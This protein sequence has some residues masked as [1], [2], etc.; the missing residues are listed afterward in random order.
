MFMSYVFHKGEVFIIGA[1]ANECRALNGFEPGVR[2]A[3][4]P[5][6]FRAVP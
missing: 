2:E 4:G 5:I 1:E 6:V 3:K